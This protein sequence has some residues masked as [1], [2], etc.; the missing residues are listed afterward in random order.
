MQHVGLKATPREDLTLGALFF[1]F[2]TLDNDLGDLSGRELDL[3][4][5][6]AVNDHL[7]ISPLVG[8]Y[9]PQKSV[10]DG[11]TQLGSDDLNTYLQLTMASFF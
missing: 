1:D 4:V 8:F 5:E 2:D 3:Y 10:D 7:L 9:K 6:W 11:G